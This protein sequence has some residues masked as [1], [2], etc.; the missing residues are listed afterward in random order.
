MKKNTGKQAR[1]S[2]FLP[3]SNENTVEMAFYRDCD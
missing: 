1:D 2:D 3:L